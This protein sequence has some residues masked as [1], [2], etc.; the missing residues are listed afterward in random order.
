MFTLT[1]TAGHH[2]WLLDEKAGG[3][4][5]QDLDDAYTSA[6]DRSSC[7]HDSHVNST[8]TLHRHVQHSK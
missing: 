5:K 7:L 4:R 6:R 1:I 8:G 2:L 3:G